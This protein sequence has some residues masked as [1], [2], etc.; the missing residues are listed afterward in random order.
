MKAIQPTGLEGRARPRPMASPRADRPP[1]WSRGR[2]WTVDELDDLAVR[3]PAWMLA[4]PGDAWRAYGRRRDL[5][6]WLDCNVR[7]DRGAGLDV[8]QL[9][10]R[11]QYGKGSMGK[12]GDVEASPAYVSHA[13]MAA[14]LLL[15]GYEPRTLAAWSSTWRVP[16]TTGRAVADHRRNAW[17]AMHGDERAQRRVELAQSIPGTLVVIVDWHRRHNR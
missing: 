16:A 13:T 15:R 4:R 12:H 3:W 10:V 11:C 5:L 8:D 1:P 6:R 2:P 14:A 17:R 7:R 9:C